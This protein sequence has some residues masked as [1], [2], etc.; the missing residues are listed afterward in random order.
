MSD[1]YIDFD[2]DPRL[3]REQRDVP[4]F[5][6]EVRGYA[7]E[8]VQ[9]YAGDEFTCTIDETVAGGFHVCVILDLESANGAQ[10]KWALRVPMPWRHADKAL[11]DEKSK[12]KIATMKC[13]PRL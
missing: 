4:T 8:L 10:K 7:E 6:S 3:Q 13:A 9:L 12:S 1:E 5:R 11:L 2:E